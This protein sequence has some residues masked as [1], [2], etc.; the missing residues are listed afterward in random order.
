MRSGHILL[1]DV[2]TV[3]DHHELQRIRTRYNG[4]EGVRISIFKQAAA[5]AVT[6]S[7][8]IA[9]R[10]EV[11][12]EELPPSTQIEMIY[13]Q[14]EYVRLATNGVRDAMLL[15]AILVTLV[16][17]FFL[18]GWRRI[19]ALALSLPVTLL[20]TFFFMQ[21]LDFSINIFTLG[22]LVVAMTVVLDNSIVMLENITRVQ[23][24]D[25]EKVT[26]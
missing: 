19:L 14:A 22:G 11:L 3:K 6:V 2:A 21:L 4:K 1:K 16:T 24:T 8:G 9:E 10:M 20:G 7:D 13:D 12:R 15:A 23:E 26:R 17:A 18:L 25:H 5:N